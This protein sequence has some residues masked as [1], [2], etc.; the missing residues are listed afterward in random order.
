MK[1]GVFYDDYP[2]N[3]AETFCD[4]VTKK[5]NGIKKYIF[6]KTAFKYNLI[7]LLATLIEQ[8]II[9]N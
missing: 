3:E 1:N 7:T 2:E 9:W 4:K 8:I 5:K 6:Y